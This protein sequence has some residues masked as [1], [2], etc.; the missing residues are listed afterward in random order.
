MEKFYNHFTKSGGVS[1]MEVVMASYM[2]FSYENTQ[3]NKTDTFFDNMLVHF[4]GMCGAV[5]RLRNRTDNRTESTLQAI[6]DIFLGMLTN[7]LWKFNSLNKAE[8]VDVKLLRK[9]G[10]SLERVMGILCTD[11]PFHAVNGAF[12]KLCALEDCFNLYLIIHRKYKL[13]STRSRNGDGLNLIVLSLQ[14]VVREIGRHVF[15]LPGSKDLLQLGTTSELPSSFT[16]RGEFGESWATRLFA[17]STF[18]CNITNISVEP[19]L[20]RQELERR[21]KVVCFLYSESQLYCDEWIFLCEAIRGLFWA[22]LILTQSTDAPRNHLLFGSNGVARKSIHILEAQYC[23]SKIDPP[24]Q[25]RSQKTRSREH[26]PFVIQGV[27]PSK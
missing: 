23:I 16:W 21:A 7:V 27:T 15:G 1:D 5:S 8:M 22:G 12:H 20:T 25:H 24:L 13:R 26:I 11:Y 19:P 17:Y 6:Q 10:S 3:P 2:A 4:N 14:N 9:V 18:I